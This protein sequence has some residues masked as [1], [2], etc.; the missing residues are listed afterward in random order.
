MLSPTV[1]AAPAPS[2][3]LGPFADSAVA[4]T[5]WITL[6]GVAELLLVMTVLFVAPFLHGSARPQGRNGPGGAPPAGR[7]Q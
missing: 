6:M 7:P 4:W 5:T 1:A 3:P 2:T